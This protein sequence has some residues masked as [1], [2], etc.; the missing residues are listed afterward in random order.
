[1]LLLLTGIGVQQLL[2]VQETTKQDR[3][4]SAT[5]LLELIVSFDGL[6]DKVRR[7]A[8]ALDSACVAAGTK[9]RKGE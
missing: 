4:G 1:M 3:F 8:E 6:V 7:K 9:Q 2:T 5:T